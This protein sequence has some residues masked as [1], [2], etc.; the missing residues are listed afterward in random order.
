MAVS[1]SAAQDYLSQRG[2]VFGQQ[3]FAFEEAFDG[4]SRPHDMA[5]VTVNHDLR[6]TWP[7]VVLAGHG[8]RVGTGRHDRQQVALVQLQ[9]TVARKPVAALAERSD[10]V[11]RRRGR[12]DRTRVDGF[13]AVPGVV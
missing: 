12:S 9:P 1:G 5:A 2:S 8:E 6:R 11:V 4:F 10:H 3:A 13:N 7:T